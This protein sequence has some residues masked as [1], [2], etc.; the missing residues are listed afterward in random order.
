LKEPITPLRVSAEGEKTHAASGRRKYWLTASGLIFGLLLLLIGGGWLL[1][2]LSNHPIEPGSPA[3]PGFKSDFPAGEKTEEI[4]A[5]QPAESP[6]S[7]K[8]ALQKQNAEQRMAEFIRLKDQLD[9]KDASEWGGQAYT[10]M[11]RLSAEADAFLMSREY[12][13]ASATYEKAAVEAGR[14][15]ERAPAV[16]QQL[17]DQ[18]QRALD[19]GN[20]RQAG[21]KFRVALM[22]EPS[23]EAARHGLQRAEKIERVMKLLAAGKQHEKKSLPAFA[24]ADYRKA[25]DLDPESKEAREAFERVKELIKDQEFQQLIS[26]GL[27]AFYDNDYQLARSKL[28]TAKSFKPDSR[29]VRDALAQVDAAIRLSQMEKLRRTAAVA[30]QSEDWQQALKAYLEALELDANL[31]FALQGRQRCLEQIRIAKRLNFFLQKPETLESDS[32]LENAVLLI[33]EANAVEPKGPRFTNQINKLT[34]LIRDAQTPVKVIIESDALT[35]IV[36][37]K[38]GKLG[39]FPVQELNLRPGTYV[40]VGARE[41]YR[42]VR[43]TIVVKP[44]QE[45]L[46]II[47]KCRDKI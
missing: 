8:S 4:V 46:R 17:L 3:A 38:V 28:V 44:G 20:G 16:L 42:D 11:S 45:P 18:G 37:Y 9:A 24:L 35:D 2:Y 14:L 5:K 30:E 34:R 22:I 10:E 40:V 47:V 27:A 19:Q 43:R 39:R 31:Q 41:G 7:E 6:E 32:Q 23:N 13:Q 29:E 21:Q 12:E 26:E 36:V 33:Q 15:A 25:L 1:H